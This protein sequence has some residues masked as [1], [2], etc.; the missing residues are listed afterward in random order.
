MTREEN[1][2]GKVR[3]QTWLT[4][5]ERR[6]AKYTADKAG[7]S[8]TEWIGDLVRENSLSPEQQKG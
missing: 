2:E 3:I 4:R 8:L 5:E 6:L 1:S 7:K